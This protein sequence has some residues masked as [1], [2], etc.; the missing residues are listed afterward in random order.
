VW[1]SRRRCILRLGGVGR[2]RKAHI[3]SCQPG[4]ERHIG[5]IDRSQGALRRLFGRMKRRRGS[6]GRGG[7][8]GNRDMS[9]RR[10]AR[11]K[12][13]KRWPDR[14]RFA[15]VQESAAQRA[16]P[17]PGH[18][19]WAL[20]FFQRLKASRQNPAPVAAGSPGAKSGSGV[21]PSRSMRTVVCWPGWATSTAEIEAS[22]AALTGVCRATCAL[23]GKTAIAAPTSQ[24]QPNPR[25]GHSSSLLFSWTWVKPLGHH[26]FQRFSKCVF[27]NLV[28]GNPVEVIFSTEPSYNLSP[29]L[30]K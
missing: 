25:A 24:R 15:T 5:G 16:R 23:A 14:S 11:V 8:E 29:S 10:I 9:S 19:R 3:L 27:A 18:T 21:R 20:F 4:W 28:E 30:R 7:I 26:A 12:G 1:K 6:Q 22:G 2:P 17:G 13:T